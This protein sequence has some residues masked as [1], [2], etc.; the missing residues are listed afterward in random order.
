MFRVNKEDILNDVI[1][2]FFKFE[3]VSHIVVVFPLLTF[4][5]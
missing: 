2:S 5:K 3:Q 1:D 4:N